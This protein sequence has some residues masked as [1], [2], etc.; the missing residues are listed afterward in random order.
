MNPGLYGGFIKKYSFPLDNITKHPYS[1]FKILINEEENS[2]KKTGVIFLLLA[3]CGFGFAGGTKESTAKSHLFGFTVMDLTTPFFVVMRDSIQKAVAARGDRLISQDGAL[4]QTKQNN[5][6]EDMITQ[7][8]EILFLN[9]VDSVSVQPALIACRDAGVKVIVLDSG[10]ARTDLVETFISSNNFQAG[11]LCGEE[12]KR[13]YP[14]GAKICILENLLAES[15]IQRVNGLEQALKGSK[16]TIVA[17]KGLTNYDQVLPTVEDM[18]QA[19]PDVDVFWGLNDP[20]ALIM[21]GVIES[22]GVTGKI[23]VV[24]I[25]GAPSGK[26]SIASGGL[27]STAAQSPATLGTIAV[28][29]AY[30][31]LAG[32]KINPSYSVDT[33]LITKDNV[34]KYPLDSW[35]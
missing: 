33:F 12:I 24:S 22:A 4:D 19:H 15:I 26:S 30:K 28:E 17:R 23:K 27:H 21:Q 32:E 10:V 13:L 16:S 18:L 1:N 25:D 34:N 6:I 14:N 29:V 8:I 7:G 9:P 2:M 35:Q 5:I 3:V 31:L 20:V 11:E